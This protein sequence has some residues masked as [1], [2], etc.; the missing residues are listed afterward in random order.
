MSSPTVCERVSLRLDVTAPVV[1][2]VISS[3]RA[4]K[5]DHKRHD[6]S[7]HTSGQQQYQDSAISSSAAAA[8]TEEAKQPSSTVRGIMKQIHFEGQGWTD[9]N[10]VT[11]QTLLMHEG[12]RQPARLSELIF[13]A[14]VTNQDCLTCRLR[15][16]GY[17]MDLDAPQCIE[18]R[19]GQNPCIRATAVQEATQEADDDDPPKRWS[20][21]IRQ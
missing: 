17:A 10:R 21:Q 9:A 15:K 16:R 1:S 11:V 8:T 7:H 14:H 5:R 6:S 20:L 18:C 4:G 3:P 13:N 12:N 2:P 19:K